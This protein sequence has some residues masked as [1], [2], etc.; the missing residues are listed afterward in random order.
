VKEEEKKAITSSQVNSVSLAVL[1]LVAAAFALEFTRFVAIP[2]VIAL[3]IYTVLAPFIRYLTKKT[4]LPHLLVLSLTFLILMALFALIVIF[5]GNSIGT[6]INGADIYRDKLLSAADWAVHTAAQY[7]LRIDGAYV[8]EIVKNLPV[9]NF[10]RGVITLTSGFFLVAVFL[11]FFFVGSGSKG[12]ETRAPHRITQEI[13]SKISFYISA[14]IVTSLVTGAAVWIILAAFQVELAFMFGILTFFLN[15]IPTLGPIVAVVLPVP[16]M[17]LQYGVCTRFFVILVL[18][19]A[20]QVAMGIVEPKFLGKVT[21]L[22]P[23][24]VIVTLVF[25]SLI[26]GIAGAFLAVP[27][28]AAAQVILSK[29]DFTKPFAE[30][31]AGRFV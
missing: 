24:T 22:H 27:L 13:Q 19:I 18:T 14:K 15:F 3:L 21:D 8:D 12:G 29:F 23:V 11:L 25:W 16:V 7:N 9:F 30:L 28:T 5:I 1:A 31:M 17:F 20:V 10:V 4:E 6:F 26:W 2:F